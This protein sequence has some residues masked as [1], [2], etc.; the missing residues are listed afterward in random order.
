MR[1]RNWQ[2][3]AATEALESRTLLASVMDDAGVLQIDLAAGERMS[4]VSTGN[5][6]SFESDSQNFTNAGVTAAA[7]FSGFDT[8]E[9]SLNNLSAYNSV[10][11]TD[12]EPGASL[13][14][15][16]S[17][18]SVYQ[19]SFE[20]DLSGETAGNQA[21][22]FV[23]ASHFGNFDLT[24]TTDRSI[25]LF[26]GSSLTT[27][28]GHISLSAVNTGDTSGSLRG[29]ALINA[30][31]TTSGE[32]DV[33]LFGSATDAG[34][35]SDFRIGISLQNGSQ[36]TSTGTTPLAGSITLDGVGGAGTSNNYGVLL[37]DGAV[38]SSV[39]GDITIQGVGGDGTAGNNHGVLI[40]DSPLIQS[41]GVGVDAATISI[42]GTGG[43][44]TDWNVGVAFSSGATIRSVDGDVFLSGN[45]GEGTGRNNRGLNMNEFGV[46]ESSG[47]GFEAATITILGVG[48]TGVDSNSGIF[49][50][51][52][53]SEIVSYDGSV[54]VSG[55][56]G[57][58]TTILNSGVW[59]SASVHSAGAATIDIIGMGGSGSSANRGVTIS[60]SETQI[61]SITGTISIDG[62]G[63]TGTEDS[64]RGV[65][66]V[67]GA[68]IR[69]TGTGSEA[70][71]IFIDGRGGSGTDSNQ[72]IFFGTSAQIQSV[73]GEI[74][75]FGTAGSGD[76]SGIELQGD[77]TS[78]AQILAVGDSFIHLNA[79]GSGSPD[80][81]VVGEGV[82]IGGNA[83]NGNIEMLADTV[84]LHPAAAVRSTGM[85]TI[86]PQHPGLAQQSISLGGADSVAGSSDLNLTDAELATL[87]PGFQSI[88]IGT[89]ILTD[90]G[91]PVLIDTAVFHDP[92][93]IIGG[94]LQDASGVD[95]T[96]PKVTL[97][98][99]IAPGLSPGMLQIDGDLSVDDDSLLSIEAAGSTPGE[100]PGFHDQLRATGRVDIGEGV[101]LQLRWIPAWQA[102]PNERLVIV[103]RVGGTGMF[104][105]LAE[106]TVLPEFF[107]A[108]ISY[109]G[110]DGDDIELTLP[111]V[112]PQTNVIHLANLGDQGVT[113]FGADAGDQLGQSVQRAGD[114]N[115]DGIDDFVIGANKADSVNNQREDAGE[116]YLIYGSSELP[117]TIDLAALGA[118]GVVIH[119]ADIFD[120][121]AHQIAAADVNGDTYSDLIIGAH[122]S[123]GAGNTV[124]S[125][126]GAFVVYGGPSLPSSIDLA[127][128]GSAG[129]T[130][131]GPDPADLTGNPVA[132]VGDINGDGFQDI[133]IGAIWA[134]SLNNAR[135]RAGEAHIIYGGDTLPATIN[136]ATV[137]AGVLRIYGAEAGDEAGVSVA[138]AGDVNGDEIDDLI[139]GARFA[140][141]RDNQVTRA[142]ETYIIYGSTSMPSAIDLAA[143]D[144]PDVVVYGTDAHDFSGYF[145]YGSG[146]INGDGFND[147]VIGVTGGD[148]ANNSRPNGGE[149]HV[150]FGGPQLPP[151][152]NLE[153]LGTA[154]IT[155]YGAD[156]GDNSGRS[157]TIVGDLNG[158]ERD[159]L[160]I[161]A[162]RGHGAYNL[163]TD[164]GEA[165]IIF[166]RPD[167]PE[168]LDL[169]IP[170][171]VDQIILGI[172]A[173]D[174]S[175]LMV[176]GAGDVN[177]DGVADLII[178]AP[179]AHSLGNAR[180]D[181]G[182]A[183]IVFGTAAVT[184]PAGDVDG[185]SEFNA[186][187][188]FLIHL[189]QLSGTDAQ[190]DQSKGSSPLSADQIRLR[191]AALEA[192][193][194]VDGDGDF[195][196]NDSFLLHLV[197][198]S[199]TDAQI[200]QS[201][202]SSML[203]AGE[204]RVRI[205]AL[206]GV[207]AAGMTT[208]GS[209]VLQP[210]I[211][212]SGQT[213]PGPDRRMSLQ[214]TSRAAEMFP[215]SE[216]FRTPVPWP[217]ADDGL[218]PAT[219]TAWENH[220]EWLAVLG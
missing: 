168:T 61:G 91:N 125:S 92:V 183:Y 37:E 119:G 59:L 179:F 126:G 7:D 182:E 140:D 79:T 19:H 51:G 122:Q 22:G 157:A 201:K 212:E 75:V 216:P 186:N 169:R 138:G 180:A 48:G 155:I 98:G 108:V 62:T 165:Y 112:I 145:P 66:I 195:D 18:S 101:E 87:Q 29:I 25:S 128:L 94:Q 34:P 21:V 170:G 137:T 152:I 116:A 14:F 17:G 93:T 40:N 147:I 6:Y 20:V 143:Q 164:T 99:R 67:S 200:E 80:A 56:G 133:G 202:G 104:A 109:S 142:G 54:L 53:G 57:P 211:A 4:V 110:G 11:I 210:V 97:G 106:G 35:A 154:G 26:D 77:T 27:F 68:T 139:I 167:F 198:L 203:S 185:N 194:D 41:T 15:N 196:A 206:A 71:P 90:H 31:I 28:D 42:I 208:L 84:Q 78:G 115:G 191:I 151:V 9:L 23:G 44:G 207:A 162:Y 118:G 192:A 129:I 120:I 1:Q 127:G 76:S 209:S 30:S 121:T 85:L 70:A 163:A 82:M 150:V 188:S 175:S 130:I 88:T 55:T 95:V 187:D 100:G 36:I 213:A 47:T 136:L 72:G 220:R 171:A 153:T 52:A 199:G 219:D 96:A 60:G 178:G 156:S 13:R 134:D 144:G 32:G 50:S 214:K 190:I 197:K 58:G 124:A 64:Q 45:G 205:D 69:S 33:S 132:S 12:S 131:F 141:G 189:V 149:T 184:L 173:E 174:Q 177:D 65:R 83:A 193:A 217:G 218:T 107:N 16:D 172:D 158:D 3:V 89:P 113:V 114:V 166:G 8:T 43:G 117:E 81:L 2:A 160:V 135:D 159:D 74:S 49:A 5:S 10:R 148:A 73:D 103:E 215:A 86:A 63:G 38:V 46:I 24:I 102:M 123:D 204:I 161:G 39:M 111:S 146:D 105:G 176:R 181:A